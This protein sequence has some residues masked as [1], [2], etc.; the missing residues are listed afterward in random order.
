MFDIRYFRRD[1]RPFFKFAK[2]IYPGQFEPSRSHKFIKLIED[3]GKLLRNYTQNIDTLEQVAGIKNVIQCHG[4]FATATCMTCHHKCSSD[5]IREKIMDQVIPMCPKCE[6]QTPQSVL[7]PDIV[8]FGESLPEEFHHQMSVDKDDC[9]LLIVI[10]SSLK[11]RPVALIPNSLPA[12]VPQILINKEHLRNLNFDVELL[13]DC[14]KVVGEICRRLGDDWAKIAGSENMTQITMDEL[15]TP[16]SSP[17]PPETESDKSEV[18]TDESNCKA[19]QEQTV[20]SENS[21]NV[22]STSTEVRENTNNSEASETESDVKCHC[23]KDVGEDNENVKVGIEK[24][25]SNEVHVCK[26]GGEN[27]AEGTSTKPSQSGGEYETQNVKNITEPEARDTGTAKKVVDCDTTTSTGQG[28]SASAETKSVSKTDNGKVSDDAKPGC[29]SEDNQKPSSTADVKKTRKMW[30][31]YRQN[32]ALRLE[33]NQFCFVPP[34]KYI[35]PEAEYFTWV[36]SDSESDDDSDHDRDTTMD[37]SREFS[38]IHTTTDSSAIDGD[39]ID[40]TTDDEDDKGVDL[41]KGA[42]DRD[43]GKDS[44]VKTDQ[45]DP[46]K[47]VQD[48]TAEIIID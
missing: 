43:V 7:K 39:V 12:H 4:S 36:K 9:D 2:E 1:Q 33:S 27:L 14:D 3:H 21:S 41:R 31:P 30:R 32:V 45:T 37:S 42:D 23:N 10:G 18:K 11:V 15:L 8:F 35:F 48:N 46:V 34:H 25:D 20:N 19:D 22:T 38:L 6:P 5:D 40:L 26:S 29:S 28:N 16:T 44:E 47:D 24:A 17:K 13:G